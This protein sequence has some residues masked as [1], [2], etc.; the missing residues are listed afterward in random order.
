M[1]ICILF[2]A[3]RWCMYQHVLEMV[4]GG[5][6]YTLFMRICFGIVHVCDEENTADLKRENYL[7]TV[8]CCSFATYI[9][10][11]EMI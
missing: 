1:E 7:L 5:S 11:N 4:D 9:P 10:L 6:Q 8:F 3:S 2:L